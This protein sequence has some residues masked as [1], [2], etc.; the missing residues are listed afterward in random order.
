MRKRC[1]AQARHVVL[2]RVGGDL[3]DDATWPA[4]NGRLDDDDA[5]D[6]FLLG[7]NP[8]ARRTPDDDEDGADDAQL[9]VADGRDV[10]RTTTCGAPAT[11]TP[12]TPRARRT[13]TATV[14]RRLGAR[15]ARRLST[16]GASTYRRPRT[17]RRAAAARMLGDTAMADS[18]SDDG[19]TAA[20]TTPSSDSD[21]SSLRA[22]GR[23]L[24]ARH[25]LGQQA[26]AQKRGLLAAR[27]IARARADSK[28][29]RGPLARVI[30][31]ALPP[32]PVPAHPDFTSY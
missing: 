24:R 20:T 9:R 31:Y 16:D 13:W 30:R 23:L 6:A 22:A 10:A 19:S 8:M 1:R 11:T 15:V 2:A 27:R 17:V 26:Q 32:P 4:T 5:V 14:G 12:A 18:G 7:A 21:A 29:S 28:G 25:D 3:E